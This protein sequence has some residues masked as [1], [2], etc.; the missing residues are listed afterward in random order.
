MKKFLTN[1]NK[2]KKDAI[3]KK[4]KKF[5]SRKLRKYRQKYEKILEIGFRE[6]QKI[7]NKYHQKEERKLLKKIERICSQSFTFLRKL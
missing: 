4:I 2:N 6:N 5:S 1:S 7:Q 3:A